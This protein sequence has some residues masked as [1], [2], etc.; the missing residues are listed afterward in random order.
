MMLKTN[1]TYFCFIFIAVQTFN[2]FEMKRRYIIIGLISI[3]SIILN[4]CGN[5]TKSTDN[6]LVD[7]LAI[8]EDAVLEMHT[9]D[10]CLIAGS[11]LKETSG[12]ACYVVDNMKFYGDFTYEYQ[13]GSKKGQWTCTHADAI[14]VVD[15]ITAANAPASA[16]TQQAPVETQQA[17]QQETRTTQTCRWC[18]SSFNGLGYN[19]RKNSNDEVN[20]Y[21]GLLEDPYGNPVEP[22]KNYPGYY[23]SRKCAKEAAN[24]G[25]KNSI[26]D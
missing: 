7:S 2:Y 16:E 17:P 14:S 11:I 20:I 4:S 21:E 23:D 22:G 25:Q 1:L 26:W 3:G 10:G 18:N 13:D 6:A 5:A 19:F 15:V 8:N 12:R 9:Q 24:S